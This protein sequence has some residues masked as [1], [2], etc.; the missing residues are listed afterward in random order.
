[1]GLPINTLAGNGKDPVFHRYNLTIPIEMQLPWK[2]KTFCNFWLHFWNLDEILN[3]LTKKMTLIVFVISK[4]R[5][6]KTW[7]DKCLKSCVWENP[8]TS[9]MV[10][11]PQQCRNL[12]HSTF[13]ISNGHCQVNLVGNTKSMRVIFCFKIIKILSKFQKCGK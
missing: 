10:N 2:Q 3:I 13:I 1:M 8:S 9:T 5:T 11:I 6:P 12:H 7:S 4:V